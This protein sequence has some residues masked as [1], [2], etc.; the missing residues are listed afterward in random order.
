MSFKLK[1]YS[2][3]ENHIVIGLTFQLLKRKFIKYNMKFDL[4]D[5]LFHVYYDNRCK[6]FYKLLLVT[7]PY[8]KFIHKT[9]RRN[10]VNENWLLP[11]KI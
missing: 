7:T 1:L 5:I 8:R 6:Q 3:T 4:Y 2:I 11:M 9:T 10:S